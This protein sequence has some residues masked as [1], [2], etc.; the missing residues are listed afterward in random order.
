LEFVPGRRKIKFGDLD[1]DFDHE[2]DTTRSNVRFRTQL[3]AALTGHQYF[4][5]EPWIFEEILQALP[6][7]PWDFTFIDL[8]SGKGRALL[9]A[10]AHGFSRV[11][12]VEYLPELHAAAESNIHRFS[13]ERSSRTKIE[14]LCLDAR[15][16]QF[17]SDPLVLYL[18]NPFPEEVLARVLENLRRSLE[19]DPRPVWI[20]YRFVEFEHL[21]KDCD[22]LEKV[23][24]TEQWALYRNRRHRS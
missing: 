20:A 24:G 13:A 2:V 7:H 19:S 8:G 18:F 3:A 11:I 15:D 12:G 10:A 5:S 14:S 22:W 9:M 4:A 16:F 23:T 1:F 6:I 21:L 17:P